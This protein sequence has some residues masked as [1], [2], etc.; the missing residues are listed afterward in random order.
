MRKKSPQIL[1]PGVVA[2]RPQSPIGDIAPTSKAMMPQETLAVF[3]G[4]RRELV[5]QLPAVL[6]ES[7]LPLRGQNCRKFVNRLLTDS[8]N[9]D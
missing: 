9:T 8:G 1:Q 5:N 6:G 2:L 7:R 3:E 4:A